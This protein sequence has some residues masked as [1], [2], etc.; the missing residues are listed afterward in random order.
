MTT[1]LAKRRLLEEDLRSALGRNEFLLHYQSKINLQ[2][3]QVSGMEALIR[4]QHPG[5]G[6]ATSGG[7]CAPIAEECGLIL[8]IG[9]RV[10]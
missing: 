9:Q 8:R 2:T 5:A 4:W 3:G 10:F 7:L 1:R 6:N